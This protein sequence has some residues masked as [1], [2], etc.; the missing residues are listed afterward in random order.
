MTRFVAPEQ[1]AA[2]LE[3]LIKEHAASWKQR[4]AKADA[5]IKRLALLAA[6]WQPAAKADVE[7][8][9]ML[10]VLLGGGSDVQD[11]SL[12]AYVVEAH[13]IA[14]ALRVI[15]AAWP[16]W[17]DR[18][19]WL[20]VRAPDDI[21]IHDTSVSW[22][23]RNFAECVGARVRAD[24]Q[25]AAAAT[26]AL[27]K[28]WPKA[29]QYAKTAL[30]YAA[31][32]PERG[33]EIARELL[34]HDRPYPHYPF[35][36]LPHFVRDAKLVAKLMKAGQAQPSLQMLDNVGVAAAPLIYRA[37]VDAR[38]KWT[39]QRMMEIAA[40]V[41]STKIARELAS[42][43]NQAPYTAIVRDYFA[44]H[45]DLLA[46]MMRDPELTYHRDDLAKLM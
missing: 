41:K 40:N 37:L 31:D 36:V 28:I 11:A 42:H 24:K 30:A 21:G 5:N 26:K 25:L 10:V 22:G 3:A 9:A 44:R 35:E 17:G 1:P 27:A 33:A 7:Q 13:G 29:P 15:V 46:K 6:G 18:D 45:R 34:A 8:L 39:R 19:K 14:V 20:V 38:S 23:K 32:D 2:M 43:V 4:A 12:A 16:W